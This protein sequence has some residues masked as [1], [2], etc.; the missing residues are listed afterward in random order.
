MLEVIILFETKI[1]RKML[2]LRTLLSLVLLIMLVNSW[3]QPHQIN[4][5]PYKKNF[6]FHQCGNGYQQGNTL[7]TKN[8]AITIIKD[9][10]VGKNFSQLECYNCNKK[11]YYIKK[12]LDK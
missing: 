2:K 1:V 11:D 12:Y 5:W 7:V 3:T 10:R 8:N 6:C 4:P 9:K